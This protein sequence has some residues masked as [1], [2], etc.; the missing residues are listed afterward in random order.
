M[1]R[2]VALKRWPNRAVCLHFI[3]FAG[4][5]RCLSH[6]GSGNTGQRQYLGHEGSGN[7]RQRQRLGHEGS[8]NT[9]QM[10]CLSH[11][12][13]GNT[14]QRQWLSH[15][16]SGNTRQRRWLTVSDRLEVPAGP[17]DSAT[18]AHTSHVMAAHTFTSH[19]HGSHVVWMRR[20]E[21]GMHA[22]TDIQNSCR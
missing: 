1:T 16:G 6:E 13:S 11:E 18:S 15:E 2:T 7:A 17:A 9:R 21:S 4:R 22:R 20:S 5:R 8:G 14:R 3:S 19:A 10:Q 12:G